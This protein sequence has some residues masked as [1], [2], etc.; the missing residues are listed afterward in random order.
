MTGE[1]KGIGT[2]F[3]AHSPIMMPQEQIVLSDTPNLRALLPI[4]HNHVKPK[5]SFVVPHSTRFK[6]Q[7]TRDCKGLGIKVDTSLNSQRTL[8]NRRLVESRQPIWE[9]QYKYTVENKNQQ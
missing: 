3:E 8:M 1:S 9:K 2:E 6:R 4:T 5:T 7:R